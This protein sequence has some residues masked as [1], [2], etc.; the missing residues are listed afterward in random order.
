MEQRSGPAGREGSAG[1]FS[2]RRCGSPPVALVIE[3]TTEEGTGQIQHRGWGDS[4][5][6]LNSAIRLS[7]T[8]NKYKLTTLTRDEGDGEMSIIFQFHPFGAKQRKHPHQKLPGTYISLKP[9][10]WLG[11]S[12]KVRGIAYSFGMEHGICWSTYNSII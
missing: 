10:S 2:G 4:T 6:I 8:Q 7:H 1:R 5:T 9:S 3:E 11:M 12:S